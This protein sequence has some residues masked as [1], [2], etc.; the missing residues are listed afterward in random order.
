MRAMLRR[1]SGRTERCTQLIRT[2]VLLPSSWNWTRSWTWARKYTNSAW[3]SDHHTQCTSRNRGK[4]AR[5]GS[6]S[7]CGGNAAPLP[8]HDAL[9][10]TSGAAFGAE[11]VPAASVGGKVACPLLGGGRETTA[12]THGGTHP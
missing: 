2:A 1:L 8:L 3:T 4:R 6:G 5:V 12:S 11:E 10:C 7:W 9:T